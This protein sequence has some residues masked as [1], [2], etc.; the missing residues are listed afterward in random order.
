VGLWVPDAAFPTVTEVREWR[1]HDNNFDNFY[2]AVTTLFEMSTTE[3]WVDV[4]LNGVDAVRVS[5]FL[6]V[7]V[8]VRIRVRAKAKVRLVCR[9]CDPNPNPNPYPSCGFLKHASRSSSAQTHIPSTRRFLRE[10]LG[11]AGAQAPLLGVP[12]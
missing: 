10:A 8:R 5:S 9:W 1:T 6:W 12:G 7:W 3:G 4:M 2:N 11:S